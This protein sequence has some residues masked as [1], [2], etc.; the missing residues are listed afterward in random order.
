MVST[1]PSYKSTKFH[2]L[3]NAEEGHP[4]PREV[5]FLVDPQQSTLAEVRVVLNEILNQIDAQV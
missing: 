1:I 4:D 2:E 5:L 3:K